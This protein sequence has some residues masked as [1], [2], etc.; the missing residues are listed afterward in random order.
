[1]LNLICGGEKKGSSINCIGKTGFTLGKK[2]RS[3]YQAIKLYNGS[4]VSF[5]AHDNVLGLDSSE[6]A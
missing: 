2:I 5:W 4:R 3:P 6:V 1:M